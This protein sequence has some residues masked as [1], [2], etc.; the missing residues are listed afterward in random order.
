MIAGEQYPST[1]ERI[2][3][4]IRQVSGR[5]D[6]GQPMAVCGEDFTIGEQDI[7]LNPARI[8][9]PAL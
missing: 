2:A 1:L 8:T 6:R 7:G 5:V 4:V 3:V 9:S